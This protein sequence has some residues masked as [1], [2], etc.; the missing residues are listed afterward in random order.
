VTEPGDRKPQLAVTAWYFALALVV[1]EV[2][3]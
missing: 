2:E 1:A 3:R